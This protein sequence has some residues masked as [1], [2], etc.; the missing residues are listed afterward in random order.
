M[1]QLTWM[2]RMAS[3]PLRD[4]RPCP[5]CGGHPTLDHEEGPRPTWVVT[6][7]ACAAHGPWSKIS[8]AEAVR[9]WNQRG[10]G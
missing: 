8:A 5:F 4:A 3:A 6:C 10:E 2:A 9:R 7:L 1:T